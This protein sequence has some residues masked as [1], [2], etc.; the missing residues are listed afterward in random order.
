MAFEALCSIPNCGKPLLRNGLCNAH[1]LRNKRYGSPMAGGPPRTPRGAPLDFFND[2]VLNH[3]GDECL[4]WPFPVSRGYPQLR[5]RHV[6]RRVCEA[7]HGPAP[8]DKPNACHEC[9]RGLQGCVSP[10]H[11][12]W[13]SQADNILDK[14]RHGTWQRGAMIGNSKLSEEDVRAIRRLRQST[15]LEKLAARYGVSTSSV[16]R[17]VNGKIWGWLD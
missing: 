10:R 12:F 11:I 7:V 13:K 16:K 4:F 1:Y 2:V 14:E 3:Q 17:V 15:T 9:G 6:H 5:G 8:A